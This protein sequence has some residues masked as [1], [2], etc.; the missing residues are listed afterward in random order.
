MIEDQLFFSK[1]NSIYYFVNDNKSCD[2]CNNLISGTII[3]KRFFSKKAYI[4]KFYCINCIK[5]VKENIINNYNDV[6]IATIT[7]NIPKDAVMVLDTKP[8]ITARSLD[9]I[10]VFS[11]C[12]KEIDGVKLNDKTKWSGRDKG[13]SINKQDEVM[14][15]I[16][17][18]DREIDM[19]NE[20]FEIIEKIAKAK[21]I[22]DEGRILEFKKVE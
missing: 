17:Q 2:K 21:P 13:I 3:I 20:G 14:K 6:M 9:E 1:K 5:K 22:I 18:Q 4:K 12:Y 7:K 19:L 8:Q 15:L 11:A 16:E 10:D